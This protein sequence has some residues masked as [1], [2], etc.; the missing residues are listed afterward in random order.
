[1]TE[2]ELAKIVISWLRDGGWEI[3]QEVP[4]YGKYIDIVA[5]MGKIVWAVECK[6]SFSLAVIEQAAHWVNYANISSVAVPI[7]KNHFGPRVCE[8]FG[9]GV[10]L[11]AKGGYISGHE[12]GKFSRNSVDFNRFLKEEHKTFCEAG[13]TGASR[14]FTPFM[15]TRMQLVKLV[16]KNPGITL[17]AAL[18]TIKH[19]YHST[20]TARACIVDMIK[21]NVINELRLELNGKQYRLFLKEPENVD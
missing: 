16:T 5:V 4:V 1:M 11:V 6:T 19:H 14:R 17:K 7:T 12:H 15:D 10:I 21:K 18:D 9:V 13:S 3:Y 20:S 8:K 2:P